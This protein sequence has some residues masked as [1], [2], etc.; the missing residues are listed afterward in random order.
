MNETLILILQ[1]I[2]TILSIFGILYLSGVFDKKKAKNF[3]KNKALL[4]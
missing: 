3:K 1:I 4:I 2:G